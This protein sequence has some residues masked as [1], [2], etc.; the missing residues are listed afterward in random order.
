MLNMFSGMAMAQNTDEPIYSFSG[1]AAVVSKY[2]WRGQRLT[3][4]WSL[5]PGMTIGV[6]GFSFNAWGT[7]DLAAA[8]EGD[9]LLLPENP[10][11]VA[12][13]SGLKG[14]F[15]E[16]DY[17]FSYSATYEKTT[18]DAGTIIY[19]FP[20]R[21][22]SLPSTTELF[23]GVSFDAP[24][25]PSARIF[26][27]LDETT[28]GDGKRGAY[29]LFSAA[30]SIPINHPVFTG[31]DFSGSLSFANSGFANFFYGADESGLHDSSLTVGLPMTLGSGWS[32][33]PFMTYSA[34][35]RGFR[36][37]QY[38]DPR[39]LYRGNAGIPSSY[40]DTVWG[41]FSVNLSF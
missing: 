16:V 12:G 40:A 41:G 7:L 22:A 18:I 24:L 39:D 4:D 6:K 20:E 28:D 26:I 35:L 23:A 13:A 2:I 17:T 38:R 10:A 27:D 30:H 3:N 15:S 21:S 9:T 5:Q 25:S 36:D 37:H 33:K 31:V 19:T 14:K 29:F 34:L 1:D 32:A 11:A 8:N